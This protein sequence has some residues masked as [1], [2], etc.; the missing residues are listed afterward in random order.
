[1]SNQSVFKEKSNCWR[2]GKIEY[3]TMLVDCANFYR[4]LH[5]A[6]SKAKHSI[7]I[8]GWDID[9]RIRLLRGDDEKN[10]DIPSVSG[11]LLKWKAKQNPDVDIY[12]LRW[13]SSLAFINQREALGRYTWDFKT[14]SNV[15][16]AMDETIP[17]GGSQHQKIIVID[18]EIAFTGGMDIA[19]QRWDERDHKINEPERTDVDGEYGPYHDIQM[20]VAGTVVRNLAE[21]ARWRWHNAT[22]KEPIPIRRIKR[23]GLKKPPTIWPKGYPPFFRN[24]DCALALTLPNLGDNKP[25]YDVKQM[26]FDLINQAKDFI[27]IENQFAAQNDIAVA[28]NKRLKECPNL[29]LVIVSSYNPQ[30]LFENEGLWA[31]RIDF[32]KIIEDGVDKSRVRLT[33]STICDDKGNPYHKRIH[34]KILIVDDRYLI[35]GSSNITNRSMA[36]DTECDLVLEA[37]TKKQRQMIATT[38]HDLLAEHTGRTV[39]QVAKL[40][41]K[42]A[43]LDEILNPKGK[44][45]YTLNEVHDEKFTDQSMQHIIGPMADPA[46]PLISPIKVTEE[47]SP[48]LIRNPRKDVILGAILGLAL[49]IFGIIFIREHLDW[50]NPDK[51]KGFLEFSRG[52]IWALPLVCLVYMVGGLIFFPV[53]VLSLATAAVFGPIWGPIYGICGTLLSGALLFWIGHFA[54][55]QGLRKLAGNKINKIDKKLQQ[56]G[57]VGMAAIRLLPIAPYSLV[58]LVAGIS[59]IRFFDFMAGTFLGMMPGLLAK[60]LVGDSLSKVFIEPSTESVI[61]LITGI[62]VWLAMI[63]SSQKF[64]NRWQ[65]RKAAEATTA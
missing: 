4:A 55:E 39:P 27:Y 34:A 42:G 29:R 25:E 48:V 41:A 14:P 56:G 51:V 24:M 46:E 26:Y 36:L 15:H 45:C 44:K 30:G 20:V 18:D 52:T 40:F 13:D 6:I 60:G 21:L 47:S 3:G 5:D 1:M 12:L 50:L 43:S 57:I 10:T 61:Y 59:S 37:K 31:A 65:E 63:I 28:L 54:G 11:D 19:V 9:S 38:R 49:L 8:L 22:G 58:N 17:I 33:C 53:T 16:F 7:F 35:V 23:T 62:F 64:A 2:T 32:K